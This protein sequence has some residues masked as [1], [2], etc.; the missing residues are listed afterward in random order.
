M[1]KDLKPEKFS[2]YDPSL[3]SNKNTDFASK[4]ISMFEKLET[5]FNNDYIYKAV[6]FILNYPKVELSDVVSGIIK[7]PKKERKLK[8]SGLEELL[9]TLEKGNYTISG[10]NAEYTQ[11]NLNSE[12]DYPY[13]LH[14]Q[15]LA[16]LLSI[17]N[18][19][20]YKYKLDVFSPDDKEDRIAN[21]ADKV[22]ICWDSDELVKYSYGYAKDIKEYGGTVIFTIKRGKK[23][24]LFGRD[25]IGID[26]EGKIYLFIDNLEGLGYKHFLSDWKEEDPEAFKV[27]LAA[28]LFFAEKMGCSYIV[29]G[30]EGAEE[31]FVSI[32]TSKKRVTLRGKNVKIGYQTSFSPSDYELRALSFAQEKYHYMR[33]V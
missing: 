16:D 26:K 14:K 9:E 13:G 10:K 21:W 19:K 8:I 17:M 27:A 29:A 30:D 25:F 15:K 6:N 33:L 7:M 32:G 24:V 22:G 11:S 3:I 1:G 18:E 12:D 4:Y 23:P 5:E 20:T 31:A 2:F 28:S